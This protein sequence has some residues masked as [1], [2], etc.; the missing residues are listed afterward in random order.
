[1][2]CRDFD[3]TT[4]SPDDIGGYTGETKGEGPS[5]LHLSII[6]YRRS[7]TLSL[8]TP[9]LYDED[10]GPIFTTKLTC[11]CTCL[12][13]TASLQGRR[14]PGLTDID[15]RRWQGCDLLG[16]SQRYDLLGNSFK[17]KA[18][19]QTLSRAACPHERKPAQ[20]YQAASKKTTYIASTNPEKVKVIKRLLT[21]HIDDN[22]LIIGTYV[23][24]L[25][26]FSNDKSPTYHRKNT[27]QKK[28]RT[29]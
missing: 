1:M 25:I 4:I 26:A 23:D 14:R 7:K 27:K 29:I 3:K 16:W 21:E 24:Q 10:W 12:G 8:S 18:I 19:L 9:P 20:K 28:R 2:D 22:V 6:I 5:L 11:S 17:N 15:P 13:V